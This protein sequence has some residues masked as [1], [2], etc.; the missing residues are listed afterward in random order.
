MPGAGCVPLQGAAVCVWG[1]GVPLQGALGQ[2]A[3]GSLGAGAVA[4]SRCC[5]R[6]GVGAG[7]TAARAGELV[8]LHIAAAVCAWELGRLCHCRVPLPCALGSLGAGAV[9]LLWSLELL[10]AG[11]CA[12]AVCCRCCRVSVFAIWGLAGGH[13]KI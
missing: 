11:K 13:W 2:G 5:V 3:L 6:L 12:F 10:G 9:P 1:L 7:A 8:P 4:G